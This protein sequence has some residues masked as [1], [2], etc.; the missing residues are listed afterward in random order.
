MIFSKYKNKEGRIIRGKKIPEK[1]VFFFKIAKC[2]FF[3][4]L[5]PLK[6]NFAKYLEKAF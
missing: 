6:S 5:G 4:H 3:N 2:K 1:Q